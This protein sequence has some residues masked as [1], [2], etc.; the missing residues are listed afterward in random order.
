MAKYTPKGVDE[1]RLGLLHEI[2]PSFIPF[3]MDSFSYIFFKSLFCHPSLL[4]LNILLSVKC[5][6]ATIHSSLTDLVSVDLFQGLFY[7]PLLV[8]HFIFF[9]VGRFISNFSC[10]PYT[11]AVGR[12]F[13]IFAFFLLQSL[14]ALLFHTFK[15]CGL[16]RFSFKNA[17]LLSF[18]PFWGG[19]FPEIYIFC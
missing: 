5:Y 3:W 17:C 11:F 4:Y 6:W 9:G 2:L 13:D 10:Y 1:G 12:C 19:W 8:F 7:H 14:N 15:E 18:S 16:D